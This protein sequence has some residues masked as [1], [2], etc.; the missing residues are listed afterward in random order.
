MVRPVSRSRV[1]HCHRGGIV[2]GVHQLYATSLR[3]PAPLMV[4]PRSRARGV[5]YAVRGSK[6]FVYRTRSLV[7]LRQPRGVED[8]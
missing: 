8:I 7:S 3:N 4:N 6:D 1:K 2:F 5:R